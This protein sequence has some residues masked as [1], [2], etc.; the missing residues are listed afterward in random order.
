[1]GLLGKG[2]SLVIVQQWISLLSG[3]ILLIYLSLFYT[4]INLWLDRTPLF[5]SIK[6]G[7][8]S[9]LNKPLEIKDIARL[10]IL[11]G[12][13]PCGLV[14]MTSVLAISSG[15]IINSLTLMLGFGIATLPS[16][17]AMMYF[18]TKLNFKN[19]NLLKKA[20]PFITF[21]I[22][23]LLI[24][25]GLNLGIPYISPKLESDKMSCCERA[26]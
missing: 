10:G 1:M 4:K 5:S 15:N 6:T 25:R 7:I 18:G 11:N 14:Y 2:L 20:S 19:R 9:I 22:A 13:L 26:K 12:L 24:L 8:S 17:F 16:M 3:I 21:S 23:I